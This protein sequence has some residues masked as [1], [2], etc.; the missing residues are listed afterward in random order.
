LNNIAAAIEKA[1]QPKQPD[2]GCD[3]GKDD[4]RSDLC[5]QWKAAD[6]AAESA[7]WTAGMFWLGVAGAAIGGGTLLAAGFAAWYARRA[8]QE[9][10]RGA[11]AANEALVQAKH[12]ARAWVSV[13]VEGEKIARSFK[14]VRFYYRVTLRNTGGVVAENVRWHHAIYDMREGDKQAVREIKAWERLRRANDNVLQPG[15]NESN[16]LWCFKADTQFSWDAS[17]P[18]KTFY[19]GLV[20]YVLYNVAGEETPRQT[21]RYF[22]FAQRAPVVDPASIEALLTVNDTS[23]PVEFFITDSRLPLPAKEIAMEPALSSAT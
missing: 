8:W 15:E 6:A 22:R 14:A 7:W 3:A 4:R 20:I 1:N 19:P 11:D 17:T 13:S 2:A 16:S 21:T 23:D 12:E 10:K 5:A 18:D 9:S